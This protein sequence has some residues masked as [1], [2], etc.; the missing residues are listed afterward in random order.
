M[1][2][3]K[4]G[5]EDRI[6]S[7]CKEKKCEDLVKPKIEAEVSKPPDDTPDEN[8]EEQKIANK[9]NDQTKV[10]RDVIGDCVID[11]ILNDA[12][13]DEELFDYCLETLP[14]E[15]VSS[16]DGSLDSILA[17]TVVDLAEDNRGDID[18]I[19]N[20]PDGVFGD[21]D[22]GTQDIPIK[23]VQTSVLS[24]KQEILVSDPL[25]IHHNKTLTKLK[26]RILK[27]NECPFN[28]TNARFLN[29]HKRSVHIEEL[30][31]QC[32]AC[33][34]KSLLKFEVA[35]HQTEDHSQED[36]LKITGIGCQLCAKGDVH[37]QCDFIK[38]STSDDHK[39]KTIPLE[40]IN[41]CE[42][43]DY[44]SKQTAYLDFHVR[45]LHK[46]EVRYS[47]E[48]CEFK[49]FFKLGVFN[50]RK[51][52]HTEAKS[53][54]IGIG[55]NSCKEGMI[56]KE[57][58][59]VNTVK[60]INNKLANKKLQKG[61]KHFNEGEGGDQQVNKSKYFCSECKFVSSRKK[62]LRT[63]QALNH[64]PESVPRGDILKCDQCELETNQTQI[65]N[66]HKRAIHDGEVRYSCPECIYKTFLKQSIKLHINKCH[67]ET[68]LKWLRVDCR[69]C[70]SGVIHK[71]CEVL[72]RKTMQ[73]A[74]KTKQKVNGYNKFKC[75][76]CEF[77][78]PKSSTID[79]H[80]A[81]LHDKLVKYSCSECNFKA[82]T[83]YSVKHHVIDTHKGI[84]GK[85]LTLAC[86]LCMTGT[87]H[88]HKSHKRTSPQERGNPI[89]EVKV[90]QGFACS[91]C[92]YKAFHSQNVD[93]H[94]REAHKES[95]T[96]SLTV[97]CTK[98]EAEKIH[99]R[100][101]TRRNI[102]RA[103]KR[104]IRREH[105][106]TGANITS[107]DCKA[108]MS[109]QTC[110]AKTVRF[111]SDKIKR[112]SL[113]TCPF[114]NFEAVLSVLVR[115]HIAT[116]HPNQKLHKCDTCSYGSNY[117]PN[118]ESHKS[119]KHSGTKFECDF[120]GWKTA[121]KVRFFE[122]RREKHGIF[123]YKS[124]YKEDLELSESLCDHCGFAATSKR[125]M[126][127]HK[128]SI[129][130]LTSNVAVANASVLQKYEHMTSAPSFTSKTKEISSKTSTS[131][132]DNYS[133]N[134][135]IKV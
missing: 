48:V 98:C 16:S 126:R 114:C 33:D 38:Q 96:R 5:G 2:K 84:D 67:P 94:I 20:A 107:L 129:C 79:K 131:L 101:D 49:H 112:N 135:V 55:C 70:Q 92:I 25:S 119:A 66:I 87:K 116:N 110:L 23:I 18:D 105:Q 69:Q 72:T 78:S 86:R 113:R 21:E 71:L 93:N 56:H 76:E 35:S 88:R 13:T 26:S 90:K 125:A 37:V 73:T 41:T 122:H 9:D 31:F 43:C 32:S 52:V 40:N 44:T 81:A 111:L 42:D 128:K 99:A 10:E 75:A 34:F 109:C 11:S 100:C 102:R 80:K 117:L 83:S 24:I 54:V 91:R 77:V 89:I 68:K 134:K 62:Y 61:R 115:K 59:F 74:M 85:V 8:T 53:R 45:S 58:D 14:L 103:I 50:H 63:H 47:C 95:D 124:K 57:C 29:E 106:K 104:H 60:K 130:Q 133:Q 39:N 3:G 65:L 132:Q 30:R 28:S 123:M 12:N 19:N 17:D 127:L 4:Y 108:C 7:S 15:K 46:K 120:C 27:C 22:A 121:W 51:S 82:C 6:K 64:G 97:G 1:D 118:L 36:D